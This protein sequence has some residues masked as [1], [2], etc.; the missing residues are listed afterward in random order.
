[1]WGDDVLTAIDRGLVVAAFPPAGHLIGQWAFSLDEKPGVQLPPTPYVLRGEAPCQVLRPGER[2]VVGECSPMADGGPRSKEQARP[3]SRSTPSAAGGVAAS[4]VERPREASIDA[5]R[6]RVIL[7]ADAGHATVF[8]LSMPPAPR[9]RVRHARPSDIT[10][11]RVCRAR[12]RSCRRTARSKSAPRHDAWFG[13]GWHLGERG[14]TQRFRWSRAKSTLAV[15]DGES[16]PIRM[17][18]ACGRECER[19]DDPSRDQR[20]DAAFVRADVRRVDRLQV[21]IPETR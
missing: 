1:M 10:A 14:G 8:R 2:T 18:F 20:H 17:F 3:R 5:E 4:G 16:R 15:A 11:V 19:R 13:A 21:R 12:F 9:R 6:S 7:R